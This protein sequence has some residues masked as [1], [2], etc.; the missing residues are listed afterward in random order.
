M[1]DPTLFEVFKTVVET[2]KASMN[3]KS[4]YSGAVLLA[5]SSD[6][7]MR[8]WALGN[9]LTINGVKM[10][11]GLQV[12]YTLVILNELL[13]RVQQRQE[14][15]Y[16]LKYGF[17]IKEWYVVFLKAF[18]FLPDDILE[19]IVPTF[20]NL[21][22]SFFKSMLVPQHQ[23]AN[24]LGPIAF[25]FLAKLIRYHPCPF[26][27]GLPVDEQTNLFFNNV[28]GF[29]FIRLGQFDESPVEGLFESRLDW[30]LSLLSVNPILGQSAAI[31]NAIEAAMSKWCA[32]AL[33]RLGRHL[34]KY[35][36]L[37]NH[38][39]FSRLKEIEQ[40]QLFETLRMKLSSHVINLVDFFDK[41]GEIQPV[42]YK[43]PNGL[44]LSED[45]FKVIVQVCRP[46]Q[47]L[48][49][50]LSWNAKDQTA[51]SAS[52]ESIHLLLTDLLHNFILAEKSS[53]S[54]Q[55]LLSLNC[56]NHQKVQKL[57]ERTLELH[58]QKVTKCHDLN[59]PL[60]LQRLLKY[61]WETLSSF[62]TS[63]LKSFRR[64]P[65]NLLNL[66][67]A[68]RIGMV[69]DA[70][71]KAL[72]THAA[73]SYPR[74][75]PLWLLIYLSILQIF[76]IV[77]YGTEKGRY[78]D[79]CVQTIA[80]ASEALQTALIQMNAVILEN[81]EDRRIEFLTEFAKQTYKSLAFFLQPVVFKSH[82]R[83]ILV[84]ALVAFTQILKNS[85]IDI[86]SAFRDN[87]DVLIKQGYI[88][89]DKAS[90]F[91]LA[92][93]PKV[94][95]IRGHRSVVTPFGFFNASQ[96]PTPNIPAKRTASLPAKRPTPKPTPLPE[97]T[98]IVQAT[99]N[100]FW[101]LFLAGTWTHPN[102]INL[103]MLDNVNLQR[104]PMCLPTHIIIFPPLSPMLFVKCGRNFFKPES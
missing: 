23:H 29:P 78:P 60:L 53:I 11:D 93:T 97:Y 103:R 91:R 17:D 42:D 80:C 28:L 45:R 12:D 37:L 96:L 77:Q 100:I 82:C 16:Y 67:S 36:T 49:P 85:D 33:G 10:T 64:V 98:P 70:V 18:G 30:L 68:H 50:S 88:D 13:C 31:V 76:E 15:T 69:G 72:A 32:N 34:E 99:S 2:I 65:V 56:F 58:I 20:P 35:P 84:N 71:L 54:V 8:E 26:L 73:E 89:D 102:R 27:N 4:C 41:Q 47:F 40:E 92:F 66:Y 101:I 86:P 87:I 5:A 59:L 52:L 3:C 95:D 21:D 61:E 44:E 1:N 46:I 25:G 94:E 9:L 48:G 62:F 51:F 57:A 39:L 24:R 79:A 22:E 6:D 7:S 74:K 19:R 63:E 90:K 75:F 43:F 81:S 55:W 83:S 104:Y 14:T 38:R